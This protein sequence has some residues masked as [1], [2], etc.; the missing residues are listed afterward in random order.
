METITQ[1]VLDLLDNSPA[2]SSVLLSDRQNQPYNKKAI[3]TSLK[4]STIDGVFAAIFMSITGGVLLTN[5]LL[6]VGASP[7]EIG[8]LSSIPM[9]LNLLQ[10]LGAYIGDR[11]NSRHYYCLWI[12][13]IARLL[14]LILVVGIGLVSWS[15]S[16]LHQLV[17]WTLGMVLVSHILEALGGSAW[18]S[19]MAV[20]VPHRLRGRYFGFRNSAASL[21]NLVGVPLLG[22]AVSAWPSG[23]IDG[24][25]V[26]LFLGVIAGIVSLWCQFFMTD[27]NPQ[28]TAKQQG[29]EQKN[30][31][32][33]GNFSPNF[34]MFLV[35][36]G[37]WTFAV[38]L[39]SP[40]FN[41]YLL[42]N[43]HLDLSWATLYGSLTAGANLVM[44]IWWGKIAD[45]I[46]NRPLLLIIG[47]LA[48]ITPLFWLGAGAD[49][50]SLWVWLPLIHIFT[51]GTWAA[52]ELCSSNIQMEVAP[53][54]HP[55]TYFA[56]A[57]AVAG[58]CGALGTTAGGFLSEI[59]II[60]GLPGLFA[61]SAGVRLFALLPL[62][63][64]NEPRSQ[65]I[66]QLVSNW[67]NFKGRSP[68]QNISVTNTPK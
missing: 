61:L 51:G 8:M 57:A 38:N 41:L 58:V 46:G 11:T 62:V 19:W 55:S 23:T 54:D 15:G 56:V 21:T 10:P 63:F 67:L 66:T 68:S 49:N 65:R 35:Y 1:P 52:I 29:E 47:I 4:A 40:F 53:K 31:S 12:F 59:P 16:N 18:L 43:L 30:V 3:R 39:S 20:L 6:Q 36:F 2:C 22:F 48:G 7:V 64:V 50:L 45:K 32:L 34:L 42:D 25:A 28:L 9:L 37:L 5:F 27:V 26:V 60:G 14:W 44:L 17:S 33:L 13:G 24:Y